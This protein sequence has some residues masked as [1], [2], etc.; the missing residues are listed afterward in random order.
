[1][2][3]YRI[4][5]PDGNTYEVTA[6]EGAT[7]QDV[8][9]YAQQNYSSA[10]AA[11][12]EDPYANDSAWD[13]SGERT[14]AG[15]FLE[16]NKAVPRGFAN[17]ILGSAEGAAELVDAAT[18][19]VGLDNLIDSGDENAVVWAANAGK[20]WLNNKSG[21]KADPR[22]QDLWTTKFGEGV[23][24]MASFFTPTVVLKGASVLNRGRVALEG[25]ETLG[26]MTR[27][28]KIATGAFAAS[29][30]AGEAAQR[31]KAAREEGL[32]VSEG[33]EDFATA[34]GAIVGLTEMLPISRILGRVPKN[35]PKGEKDYLINLFKSAGIAAAEE[36]GQEVSAAILQNMIE[37]GYN[38][39]QEILEESLM[40]DLTIGAGVG[41]L[42]D[43]TLNAFAGRRKGY[44]T[45]AQKENERKAREIEARNDFQFRQEMTE[46]K[47]IG[48]LIKSDPEAFQAEAERMQ[49]LASTIPAPTNEEVMRFNQP[50][51][52]GAIATPE[53]LGELYS[54]RIVGG[55]G[56]YFPTNTSFTVEQGEDVPTPAVGPDGTE[57][58]VPQPSF[59]VVDS[60]G[61]QYGQTLTNPDV[62]SSLARNLNG[63]IVGQSI[64]GSILGTLMTSP[65]GYNPEQ[66]TSLFRYGFQTL[67]PES[68][69]VTYAALNDAAGTTTENGYIEEVSH[70]DI[71]NSPKVL[72]KGGAGKTAYQVT[73]PNGKKRLAVG[74]TAS[75]E[76]NRK[77]EAAGL[78]PVNSFNIRQAREALGGNIGTLGNPSVTGIQD[79]LQY[80]PVDIGGKPAV[81][82]QAREVLTKRKTT[83]AE[84]AKAG[85]KQD[86]TSVLPDYIEFQSMD[87]AK[88]YA[89]S[90]NKRNA[91]KRF[92]PDALFEGKKDLFPQIKA[93]LES[94]NIDAEMDSDE[95][96]QLVKSFTGARDAKSMSLEDQKL[97][98]ARL[99]N[100]PGFSTKTKLPVFRLRPYSPEQFVKATQYQN[101][102]PGA[103]TDEGLATALGLDPASPKIAAIKSDLQKQTDARLQKELLKD[104]RLPLVERLRKALDDYG[105]SSVTLRLEETLQEANGDKPEGYFERQLSEIALAIDGMDTELNATDEQ[106][107]NYLKEVLS[108]EVVHALRA[109]DLW[110]AKEWD[111]LTQAAERTIHPETGETFA[112]RARRMYADM[113]VETQ[114]EESIAELARAYIA[115]KKLI[116]GKPRN[117]LERMIRL[118]QRLKAFV[119]NSGYQSFEA[120]LNDMRSGAI[121]ARDRG[122]VRSLRL[123]KNVPEGYVVAD[124]VPEGVEART[125]QDFDEAALEGAEV[126]QSRKDTGRRYSVKDITNLKDANGRSLKTFAEQFSDQIKQPDR[127][128][129][130]VD[131]I[132]K[133]FVEEFVNEPERFLPVVQGDKLTADT[134]LRMPDGTMYDPEKLEHAD[135]QDTQITVYNA[136]K[137]GTI[138]EE[139]N[140]QA[141]R[142]NENRQKD[143]SKLSRYLNQNSTYS[144]A[145]QAL[146]MK[147]ASKYGV[148]SK[149]GGG[150]QLVAI[151][152]NNKVGV[153]VVTGFE[154]S[155]IAGELRK[156]KKLKE[157]ML[158]GIS[159]AI[160]AR[161]KKN[162]ELGYDGW[163]TFK[164]SNKEEDAAALKDGC[165][166]REWCTA[167]DL[168]MARDQLS[169][170]DFHVYYKDG[171]PIL[172]LHTEDGRLAEAPR[173]SLPDQFMTEEE[174]VIA[175]KALR[176]GRVTGGDDYLDDRQ[177]IKDV[178][179]G[180]FKDWDDIKL[181]Q[182]R[183]RKYA[184]GYGLEGYE[185]PP[186]VLRELKK[187]I[188]R[189]EPKD[190]WESVG[191][192]LKDLNIDDSGVYKYKYVQG[193]VNASNP[194]GVRK[195]P[196]LEKM[197]Y[198]DNGLSDEQIDNLYKLNPTVEIGFLD[199]SLDAD[200][201]T[202][203]IGKIS[204][205]ILAGHRL[206]DFDISRLR[207]PELNINVE[208]TVLSATV[209][210]G[211][212]KAKN[213][214]DQLSVLGGDV[215]VKNVKNAHVEEFGY[216]N[217]DEFNFPKANLYAKNIENLY[218]Y[219]GVAYAEKVNLF[220]TPRKHNTGIRAKAELNANS[221]SVGFVYEGV[222]H[223]I[224]N[225]EINAING[226]GPF[227]LYNSQLNIDKMHGTI[228]PRENDNKIVINELVE[229]NEPITKEKNYDK[230]FIGGNIIAVFGSDISVSKVDGYVYGPDKP[231]LSPPV[232]ANEITGGS[233]NVKIVQEPI[234]AEM[235]ESFYDGMNKIKEAFPDE[236][237]DV[238]YSRKDIINDNLSRF[239]AVRQSIPAT[240]EVDGVQRPTVNSNGQQIDDTEEKIRNFWK[241]FGNSRM[242]DE[243]GRPKVYYHGTK[244]N[245]DAFKGMSLVE[246]VKKYFRVMS[247][248]RGGDLREILRAKQFGTHF[249]TDNPDL[250]SDYA[251]MRDTRLDVDNSP[252][253]LPVYLKLER[254]VIIDLHGPRDGTITLPNGNQQNVEHGG[255]KNWLFANRFGYSL[256]E[257]HNADGFIS[258]NVFD[259]VNPADEKMPGDYEII[260][261]FDPKQSKSSISNTGAYSSKDNRLRYSRK[262]TIN[263]NLSRFSAVRQSLPATIEVDG[264][265]RPTTNSRGMPIF[266]GNQKISAE[267]GIRNFWRWYGDTE[268]LDGEGRPIPVYHS[269]LANFYAFGDDF[270][271]LGWHF[272]IAPEQGEQIVQN[273]AWGANISPN[274]AMWVAGI[275]K[276]ERSAYWASL[277]DDERYQLI[278]DSRPAVPRFKTGANTMP[279]YLRMQNPVNVGFDAENWED[280]DVLSAL[281]SGK[282]KPFTHQE[283]KKFETASDVRDALIQKGYDGI[284]YDNMYEGGFNVRPEAFMVFEGFQIKSALGNVGLFSKD[285][286]QINY[287]RKDLQGE[288]KIPF[289]VAPSPDNK[290]RTAAWRMV[291]HADKVRIT[292]NLGPKAVREAS[293]ILGIDSAAFEPI[294]SGQ[295]L[296]EGHV[297]PNQ[298]LG[299]RQQFLSPDEVLE[300]ASVLGRILEQK[301][302]I[303]ADGRM[304][305]RETSVIRIKTNVSSPKVADR[306]YA[307]LTAELGDLG[308]YTAY[309]NHID[310]FNFT[311]T[312]SE[313]LAGRFVELLK[314]N[315]PDINARVS[316]DTIQSAYLENETYGDYLRRKK[317]ANQ[318][319]L[320]RGIESA[321]SRIIG[322]LET[323]IS[324][325][326]QRSDEQSRVRGLAPGEGRDT[327]TAGRTGPAKS[328]EEVKG[329][330]WLPIPKLENAESIPVFAQSKP[331]KDSVSAFVAHYSNAQG[332][333]SLDGAFAGTGSAGREARRFGLGNYGKKSPPGSLAR[334]LYFYVQSKDALPKKERV[335]A[336]NSIYRVR[337]DNLYDAYNDPRGFSDEAGMN[338]DYFEEL[339]SDAGFDG[340][341]YTE[342]PGIDEPTVVLF[343]LKKK[344]PVRAY[345]A[346]EA[347]QP[348]API[349]EEQAAEAVAKAKKDTELTPKTAI[350]LYGENASPD[351]L[352]VAQNPEKGAKLGDKGKKKYSRRGNE[353]TYSPAAQ[354][355]IDQTP[356]APNETMGET[357]VKTMK[358]G[359]L[360]DGVDIFRQ[361][362]V[363]KGARLERQYK[364]NPEL[365]RLMA[366][367]SALTAYEMMDHSRSMTQAA[368]T[369][370]VPVYVNGGF[371]VV[372][373]VHKGKTIERGFLEV[374]A[375]LNNDKLHGNLERLAHRYAMAVRGERLNAEG[376]LTPVAPGEL[377]ILKAEIQKYRNPETGRPVIEEWYEM[378]QDYNSYIVKFLRDTG[379]VDESGAELWLK[380]ADY[381]PFYREDKEGNLVH[382]KVFGGLHTASQ[383]KS[384]GKSSEDLNIDMVTAIVNNI[385]AAIAM[386][387]KNVAQQRV[388]RD[389]I[390]LGLASILKKGETVGDRNS[391]S[392]KIAGKRYTAIIED[393][394]IYQSML[395]SSEIGM[396]NLFGQMLRVPASVLREL[397][398]RD[399]GYMVANMFRDTLSTYV[400]TGA[401]VV[402]LWGTAKGFAGDIQKLRNLGVLG[403]YDLRLDKFGVR[404][405]YDKEAKRMGMVAGLNWI[406]PISVAWDMMGRI[407]ERSEAATRLAVYED[408]LK[409]TG[410]QVEAQYQALSVMN[411]GRRGN[412]ALFRALTAVVPFLNARV[413]GLDK[414]Y[415]AGTGRVGAQ[416]KTDAAGNVIPEAQRR[417]NFARF[418]FRAGLITAVSA[419]YYAMVSDDDE[420]L[421]ASPEIRDNYYILPI[422]KG[423]IESGKPGLSVRLPIPF[424]VGILFKVIPERLIAGIYG[425][426][427]SK[428]FKDSMKRALVSTLGINPTPQAVLP[429]AEALVNKD[430]YSGRPIVPTYMEN[431][432]PEQQK[433]FYTNQLA[434]GVA[435]SIGASPMKVQHLMQGYGGTLGGYFLQAIDSMARENEM[436]LP[437][438]EWY[439]KPFIKRFFT[440]A[441]Q[442]GLQNKFYELKDDVDGI[443]QTINRLQKDGRY[444]ELAAFYAKNGHM[445][446]MRTDLNY[447]EKQITMLREQRKVIEQ[448]DIDPESKREAIEQINM[449]ISAT[450]ISVPMYREMAYD[451]Q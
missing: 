270:R 161:K 333:M 390:G 345:N 418:V 228:L 183:H 147:G 329:P 93:L 372:P 430:F 338:A 13:F 15:R 321:R 298:I 380:Q 116:G 16:G 49:G 311:D 50:S 425:D 399:P 117:L 307:A 341:V 285:T 100:L 443:T 22:Y 34:Q 63:E 101:Q 171:E 98:Y 165:A 186:S 202:Y 276:D 451:K 111:I 248:E 414:L 82:S 217:Q 361:A 230:T 114:I 369:N 413:Q 387:M 224:Y 288:P 426:D 375:P 423:D 144:L 343:G 153:S 383:F 205:T 251:L 272:G 209:F 152:D 91:D 151:S 392:F 154:A 378:W 207:V 5:S 201:G 142:I 327:D 401:E 203:N 308:G 389:Q 163:K 374:M 17:T 450:L 41:A 226:Y 23:G 184:V 436:V 9:A 192:L 134:F 218:L 189:R 124:N 438:T 319:R 246:K 269:T 208:E 233:K 68:N 85:F 193:K 90:L 388:I 169:G 439:Q 185:F 227:G 253:V 250:A 84:K 99:R 168:G 175:E 293:K 367:S 373:F 196:D 213:I 72:V 37:R 429:I 282:G 56:S 433:T 177:T 53:T 371:K 219:N 43:I 407:S 406:N 306:I 103:V 127:T 297:N 394:L 259:A 74:L 88:R 249:F 309:K 1:M 238:R 2:P 275:P 31:A 346:P 314:T 137:N 179:S 304:T 247:S 123:T 211:Q 223:D 355:L 382:P 178:M 268:L 141:E 190:G 45:D 222:I 354:V 353:P 273:E 210:Y 191:I 337:L 417:K 131:R 256:A 398:I 109:L 146:I 48:E 162:K 143:L 376:K 419:M 164:R 239:S 334:R 243:H 302:M 81:V 96:S 108:H 386:G 221:F 284:F 241:W 289:E 316:H 265:Q 125:V 83:M 315:T 138:K 299:I 286:N 278:E 214:T 234:V 172:A 44:M 408:V 291:P 220:R 277:N 397:I 287:S 14:L 76:L 421:N 122:V 331:K 136:V 60:T 420:Y 403:G 410:N 102:N 258:R 46:R 310:V 379:V 71:L 87:D 42:A 400:T 225:T 188:S 160:E 263:D 58:V 35:I 11:T 19:F 271:E 206:P 266:V 120:I 27:A 197:Y 97:F 157:A 393:P 140:A 33:Q 356:Q 431:L 347:E 396:D 62:A 255:L 73:M 86:G 8:L 444:D 32:D 66:A 366:D 21:L 195:V 70:N 368:L 245:F 411:Y 395:P 344:V 107:L 113:S 78:P 129:A 324:R 385:D 150:Y 254:P 236:D 435:N 61:K 158:D 428:D 237:S 106:R 38:P 381:V 322:E 135:A 139:L 244:N 92:I 301:A 204:G 54:L 332:L 335:V 360:R 349:S 145:E 133:G 280:M 28:E 40:D 364:E 173:G 267:D 370:G 348:V 69:N 18:N 303:A 300:F 176:A 4:T 260:V 305:G 174:E 26:K 30:G 340:A 67:N 377:A 422:M 89:D 432:L 402:P 156:G 391:V 212:F 424:E 352:F 442:P 166:G 446:E 75:Q 365:A 405:F 182:T 235:P 52:A 148:R 336:G 126:A 24:S 357:L 64:R 312:D 409:R 94:K 229:N 104:S 121:G 440:T 415:Q 216:D 119:T 79:Q 416:Y 350:P 55:L 257:T 6:P 39:N 51:A 294:I 292:Q 448:M 330:D 412:N 441:N 3:V 325:A 110:T 295:G 187:E 159:S 320:E 10:S 12:P 434:E 262:D 77:R 358:L 318:E 274:Y 240:I 20:D 170:G 25:V 180:K 181:F 281:M 449:M 194:F 105:L 115:N 29:S 128:L 351:A 252:N 59:K 437:S 283:F 363:F 65:Q 339:V 279:V 200:Y 57:T 242:V 264:V 447:L 313:T 7:E 290:E 317:S 342:Q 362:I 130:D 445:Y 231:E 427:T 404:K 167:G 118:F 323:S 199:G 198:K 155:A 95:I 261:T 80:A 215:F 384:V 326:G 132:A 149:K 36:G 359:P 232:I 296:F 328:L 112:A 47:R